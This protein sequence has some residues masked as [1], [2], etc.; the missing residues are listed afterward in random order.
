VEI[1]L[2]VMVASRPLLTLRISGIGSF[3]VPACLVVTG[4]LAL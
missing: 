2:A 1:G 3:G 4:R